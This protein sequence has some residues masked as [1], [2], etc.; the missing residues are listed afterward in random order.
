[1]A[2][3]YI[4]EGTEYRFPDDFTDEQAQK[5]L[6]SQGI[7]KPAPAKT[8]PP[9]P[10]EQEGAVSRFFSGMLQQLNPIPAVQ[11]YFN[12]PG[13]M[14]KIT[15]GLRAAQQADAQGR[16]MN[17]EEQ[18]AMD[19][20]IGAQV[21]NPMATPAPGTEPVVS[22]TSKVKQG[23]YAG[24]AGDIVGG[25]GPAAV[26][27]GAPAIQRGGRAV[28]RTGSQAVQAVGGAIE[29]GV[30]STLGPPNPVK[31]MTQALKP[32]S[33]STEFPRALDRGLPELKAT[34][35]EL[36]RAIS[37]TQDLID[38]AKLAKKRLRSEFESIAGPQRF[39]Q[40]DGS[41]IAD[42]IE[43]S[44]PA[45]VKLENPAK[46]DGLRAIADRYRRAF[47]LDELE[48]LIQ[49]S[50]AEL[51]AYYAKNPMAKSR[52]LKADPEVGHTVAQAD[53]AR[54]LLYDTLD[55]GGQGAAPREINRRYGAVAQIEE[56]AYRRQNVA[57]RQAPESLSQQLSKWQA[58]GKAA[59][60]AF[61][62]AKA[63]LGGL[64]DIIEASAGRKAADALREANGTDSLIERTFRHYDRKPIPVARPQRAEP[65][66]LLG[67]GPLVTPAPAD[68]SGI[69]VTSG[70]PYA[71]KPPKALLGP[72]PLVTPP[73]ADPS[74]VRALQAKSGVV[75]DPK[76]GRMKRVYVSTG[77]S[78]KR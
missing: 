46:A 60:G 37:S 5:I 18:Q 13:E 54:K 70:A 38:A 64:A 49:D 72:A 22:A 47:T 28:V 61:R 66:A 44:I 59:K 62:V 76:T 56:E 40:I 35:A 77:D 68:P 23:D 41:P 26:L 73:P 6:T 52:A 16:A 12:R 15:A 58:A 55:A 67:P 29:K 19:A 74:G 1:M 34:E 42:A 17:P 21:S 3:R 10:T 2:K 25:Y 30:L 20:A 65:K 63:D 7:I 48:Q 27:A 51:N 33:G 4:V 69:T 32:R 36:G 78:P 50:N 71:P 39:Q 11:E 24:A 31:A 75:R 57:D 9:A 14:A 53:A 45:K 8:A 43:R